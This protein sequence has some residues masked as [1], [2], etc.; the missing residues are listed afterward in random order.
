MIKRVLIYDPVPFKGGSKKV[1]NTIVAELPSSISVW[2]ISNDRESWCDS[3]V[4]FVQLFSPH[5]LQNKTSGILY[6]IKHFVYL[7]SLIVNIIKLEKFTKI[8]GF[9][10]PCVDFSIYLLSELINIEIIQL[11][12]GDVANSKIAGFALTRANQVFYLPSTRDSILQVLKSYNNDSNMAKKKFMPFV[13]GLNCS[14]IKVKETGHK[15]RDKI[16]FLWAA[17]LLKWKRVE[18]FLAAMTKLNSSGKNNDKYF[19]SVCYIEPKTDVYLDIAR[20]DKI[21]NIHWYSDPKNLNDIRAHSSIF[22]STSEDEPFGLSILESMTAGLAIV[23]PA[24]NAYWDQHLTD[25]YNC[26]KYNPN[27]MDSLALALTRLI[28]DPPLLF[29]VAQHAKLL[30]QQYCNLQCYAQILK[31]IPN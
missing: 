20:L 21:D 17:S 26:V 30:S 25:G 27:N 6:F 3:N 1:M 14:T 24:D 10:G 31:C 12:Q 8:I 13:N 9:S 22:I 23:I 16:G 11:I 5:F 18:L 4:H 19:A 28:N 2:V 29:K 15:S 7:F